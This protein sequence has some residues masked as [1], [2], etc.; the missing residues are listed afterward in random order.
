MFEE[1]EAT[2]KLGEMFEKYVPMRG[3]AET[4]GGEIVRAINRL[5]YR[6]WNDGDKLGVDY[7][8]ETCNFAGR[9]LMK[10]CPHNIGDAVADVWGCR[11]DEVYDK[12]LSR[13]EG[14]VVEFLEEFPELFGVKNDDDYLNYKVDEDTEYEDEDDEWD[15]WEC[16]PSRDDW[17]EEDE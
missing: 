10:V 17:D 7:G 14:L 5:G 16:E 13:L 11:S 9:F 1:T 4:K 3:P 2:K 12:K 6:W 15:R 8:N